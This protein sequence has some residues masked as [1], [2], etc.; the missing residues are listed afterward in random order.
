[1]WKVFGNASM[2]SQTPGPVEQ[3]VVLE[4]SLLGQYFVH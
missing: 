3:G 4:S 1:V 2:F